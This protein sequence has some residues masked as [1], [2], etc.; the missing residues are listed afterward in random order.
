MANPA[1]PGPNDS[2]LVIFNVYHADPKARKIFLIWT[3]GN[4]K[5]V[6]F[7]TS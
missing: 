4:P 2:G 3:R 1:L 6:R 5:T 7:K